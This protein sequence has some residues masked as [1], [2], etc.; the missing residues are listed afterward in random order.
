MKAKHFFI[1]LMP[2]AL[3]I[4][5]CSVVSED[6]PNEIATLYRNGSLMKELRLQ[7]ASFDA[8]REANDYNI[9]NCEMTARLLNQNVSAQWTA[10]GAPDVGFWCEPG[11]YREDGFPPN[12]FDAE[13]PTDVDGVPAP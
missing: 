7:F 5:S 8:T 4:S 2:S 12:M 11:K 6:E 10:N 1:G 9:K 3:L 13:F